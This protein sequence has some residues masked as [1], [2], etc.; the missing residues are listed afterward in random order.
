MQ[1][2][3]RMQIRSSSSSSRDELCKIISRT[4]NRLN[5]EKGRLTIMYYVGYIAPFIMRSCVPIN[6]RDGRI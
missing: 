1:A 3:F 2:F 5:Y 4:V 6:L